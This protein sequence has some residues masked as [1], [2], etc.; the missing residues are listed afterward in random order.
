M[1]MNGDLLPF[2]ATLSNPDSDKPS[3]TFYNG[4]EKIS[5]SHIILRNDSLIVELPVFN[6][7]I[8]ARIESPTMIS[9]YYCDFNKENYRIPLSAEYGPDFRFTNTSS[10]TE[11]PKRYKAV[12]TEGD[13]SQ[14][15][16]IL[17][18][19]NES[20]K[21]EGTFMT[22]TGDYRHLQGNIMNSSVYLSTFDGSHAFFFRADIKNDSLVNGIFKSGIHYESSWEASSNDTFNLRNPNTLTTSDHS[23]VFDF[24][25]PNHKGDTVSWA[26]L[27]LTGK[28]VVVD[29]MGTWCP[30]CMDAGRTLSRASEIYPNVVIL[31]ILF[32]YKD[33][34]IWARR[35]YAKF[36]ENIDMPDTFLFG[37]KAKKDLAS[38][39]FPMLSGISSFPTLIYIDKNR[40]I[41]NIYTGFYG[42]ATGNKY[43]EFIDMN[44]SILKQLSS[45]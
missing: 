15:T 20:G 7:A 10:N 33:D 9:G 13:S 27:N 2:N 44:D 16:S 1:N 5:A 43:K 45:E 36:S 17:V 24:L 22:E 38:S 40:Q 12:F 26:D 21:L 37:G 19:N 4:S 42:P 3:I 18:L 23:S 32:E 30:N 41:R 29:I 28:V 11:I 34:L 35:A 6:T 39:K 31:P 25:L 14:D 8:L